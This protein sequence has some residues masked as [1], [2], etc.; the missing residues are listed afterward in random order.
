[1]QELKSVQDWTSGYFFGRFGHANF[2]GNPN[3]PNPAPKEFVMPD[4]SKLGG[5]FGQ[6]R[7]VK[8]YILSCGP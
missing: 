2:T 8:R 5:G 1:P 6:G 7:D 4:F 3:P